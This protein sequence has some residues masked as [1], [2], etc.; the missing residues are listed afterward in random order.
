M[1]QWLQKNRNKENNSLCSSDCR[2][3]KHGKQILCVSA[4]WTTMCN[5]NK[6]LKNAFSE[7]IISLVMGTLFTTAHLR[8]F[9]LK[10]FFFF[11]FFFFKHSFF[12]S[13]FTISGFNKFINSKCADDS[14]LISK[15]RRDSHV[16]ERDQNH[17]RSRKM[18]SL[19]NLK[20]NMAT[21]QKV[22]LIA[23]GSFNPITNMHLRMFGMWSF[24][25]DCRMVAG[26]W[27]FVFD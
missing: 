17:S 27:L 3:Q 18:F 24:L 25:G 20:R 2:N 4:A 6:I 15:S 26:L 16:I 13:R 7:E 5:G 12:P 1:Q 19:H 8:F 22:V 21:T 14:Y 11:F 9:F 23:C 10:F